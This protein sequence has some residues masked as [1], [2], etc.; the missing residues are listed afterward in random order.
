MRPTITLVGLAVLGIGCATT[1]DD[2][3]DGD[4]TDCG[5][6]AGP[7]H[8]FLFDDANWT[9][10]EAVDYP[11]DLGALGAVEP[12][13]DWY[14]EHER[15]VPGA[16]LATVEGLG[17]RLSG[18]VV[19]IDEHQAELAG[20]SL[21]GA[22]IA[23]L[24]ALTGVGQDGEPTLVTMSVADGYTLM[25]LT[26]GLDLDELVTVATEVRAVCET[27]WIDAGGQILDCVPTDPGCIQPP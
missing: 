26:Y 22:T 23:G 17:L 10:Q 19:G 21:Q 27:E 2:E 24:P 11:E 20:A 9:L 15:F 18:H 13:L 8:Y 7:T 25:L 3:P 12:S 4:A 5:F 16:D 1:G 14:T 6:D